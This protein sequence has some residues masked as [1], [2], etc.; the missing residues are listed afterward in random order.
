MQIQI[1]TLNKLDRQIIETDMQNLQYHSAQTK[2]YRSPEKSKQHT[3]LDIIFN[4]KEK[5]KTLLIRKTAGVL[6]VQ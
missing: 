5:E 6:T 4:S 1:A 3:I 2:M